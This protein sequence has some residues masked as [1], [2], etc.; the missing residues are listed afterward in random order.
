MS[1][2]DP[3]ARR[4]CDRMLPIR[5]PGK[6]PHETVSVKY[7]LEYGSDEVQMHVDA[8]KPGQSVLMVDDLIATGGT[9][10]AACDLVTQCGARILGVAV[11]I[12]LTGLGGRDLLEPFDIHAQLTY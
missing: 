3:S 1:W 12:E 6:L 11:L 7:D 9:M 10:R 8:V 2:V 5:K 4:C